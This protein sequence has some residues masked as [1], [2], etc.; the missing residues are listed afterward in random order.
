[1]LYWT[2]K[3]GITEEMF[4][5]DQGYF[6]AEFKENLPLENAFLWHPSRQ[7]IPV[8][9]NPVKSLSAK[10]FFEFNQSNTLK[11]K[12]KI[13]W[14][15]P[16]TSNV[17]CGPW[18]KWSYEIYVNGTKS[19]ITALTTYKAEVTPDKVYEL[20]V[21]ATSDGGIGPWSDKFIIQT[22]P[23]VENEPRILWTSG[24]L[25]LNTNLLGSD[26]IQIATE[27][28]NIKNVA[29]DGE[30]TILSNGT[31]VIRMQEGT[32][33]ELLFSSVTPHVLAIEPY[34]EFIYL[35][36]PQKQIVLRISY[37]NEKSVEEILPVIARPDK[38]VISSKLAQMCWTQ[39]FSSIRCCS[40]NGENSRTIYKTSILEG[41]VIVDL[42]V[43]SD[44]E[45]VYF[46]QRS[47]PDLDKLELF[48]VSLIK[49][50]ESVMKIGSVQ[51]KEYSGSL[52]YFYGQVK[53]L[54][55]GGSEISTYCITGQS[56]TKSATPAKA[57][58]FDLNPKNDRFGFPQDFQGNNL[59]VVPLKVDSDSISIVEYEDGQLKLHWTSVKNVNYG[60]LKYDI[61]VN[62]VK[63]PS[64][65]TSSINLTR[66]MGNLRPFSELNIAILA[67]TNWAKS[68]ISRKKL[69][70]PEK[71]A[72]PPTNLRV[73]FE[74]ENVGANELTNKIKFD[75]R[76]NSPTDPNG[77]LTGYQARVIF[78]H[79]NE[80]TCQKSLTTENNES[81]SWQMMLEQRQIEGSEI[82]IEL[83]AIN[84]AGDS[85][86]SSITLK[87]SQKSGFFLY[88]PVPRI[89]FVSGHENR[90]TLWDLDLRL[91]TDE[92][93]IPFI[94][95]KLLIYD[96]A[97][98]S[99]FYSD[100]NN[101][102][103]AFNLKTRL[104]RKIL[105]LRGNVQSMTL[106]YVGRYIYLAVEDRIDIVE[107]DLKSESRKI[108]QK[109]VHRL[110]ESIVNM[111]ID[112]FNNNL[113]FIS[114][115]NDKLS[116]RR[117]NLTSGKM[118]DA[119]MSEND[120]T[121]KSTSFHYALIP[122][123]RNG[124]EGL[125]FSSDGS[126]YQTNKDACY[127]KSLFN[128]S[129]IVPKYS[130]L[131]SD[132]QNYYWIEG[133]TLKLRSH[134]QDNLETMQL[135]EKISSIVPI[136]GACQMPPT[137]RK[138]LTPEGADEVLDIIGKT[139]TSLTVKVPLV[140]KF[141]SCD[142][143]NK[144]PPTRLTITAFPIQ[145]NMDINMNV[146]KEYCKVSNNGCY[147]ATSVISNQGKET[148][149]VDNL[150][151]NTK[152][153]LYYTLTNRYVSSSQ[154]ELYNNLNFDF[155][156]LVK[157]AEGQPSGPRNVTPIAINP[158]EIMVFWLP[159]LVANGERVT[160]EVHYQLD[161]FVH[162]KLLDSHGRCVSTQSIVLC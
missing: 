63:L 85:V 139:D 125:V 27:M 38:L 10:V 73:F 33:S 157:T 86:P 16:V 69:F 20:S 95:P 21:R 2:T 90:V 123:L 122:K 13:S 149:E 1:M 61:E 72:S 147:I 150:K 41:E 119:I 94:D 3:D 98:Q 132:L 140:T 118:R 141:K 112:P 129:I 115:K 24:R 124:F 55:A 76:W 109:T 146:L 101:A 47:F 37:T 40:L 31:H 104:H 36:M 5:E 96:A 43:A 17:E 67:R 50:L 93:A 117:L 152:Y 60:E 156:T 62:G 91:K 4:R 108:E 7:P 48:K 59:I 144:L 142:L 138:C 161:R 75:I 39:D 44:G 82:R 105:N 111:Q 137:N 14:L 159:S 56:L 45:F 106:D 130:E 154:P 52:Q 28:L 74:P 133:D 103:L 131:V 6:N 68:D 79:G 26:E 97:E 80:V 57:S 23:K 151:P 58:S 83:V 143:S 102:L 116:L 153:G 18:Q 136:C 126:L 64:T 15:K 134:H 100:K 121:C 19:A 110:Q 87:K 53:W 89:L 128:D 12:L 54:Q 35:S 66:F 145:D 32:N 42:T 9:L 34:A 84:G 8:P 81:L 51:I 114:P 107:A 92:M 162:G 29:V 71:I 70:S 135:D 22:L 155:V 88:N 99:I 11:Q 25:L 46:M 78:C 160:Y 30:F 158:Q 127:C 113:Y 120:C 148:V 77:L 49:G 65:Q